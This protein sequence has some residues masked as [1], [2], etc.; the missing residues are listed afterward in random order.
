MSL[1]SFDVGIRNLAYCNIIGKKIK[2]WGVLDLGVKTNSSTDVITRALVTTLDNNKTEFSGADEVIIEKQPSRN[3]K[4]RYIEGMMSAYFFINGIQ[5]GTL[6][7]MQSYSPKH[8][9]GKNT[10]RGL[11]NY[12]ERKKLGIRRCREFLNMT[13]ENEDMKTM[14]EKSKKKDDLADSLLQALSY[15]NDG[16]FD[17]L[18]NVDSSENI[19]T[20]FEDTRARKPTDKQNRTRKYTRSNLKYFITNDPTCI[21]D[22][23]IRSSFIRLFGKEPEELYIS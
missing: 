9:L 17:N 10:K 7:K 21:S 11:S 19:K 22:D 5:N 2:N 1:I 18:Q 20:A 4:M 12:S 6:K 8:K 16:I 14:F 15:N 13:P 3:P 23:Y